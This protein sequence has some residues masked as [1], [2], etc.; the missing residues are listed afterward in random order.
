MVSILIDFNKILKVC[1]LDNNSKTLIQI[2]KRIEKSKEMTMNGYS[3]WGQLLSDTAFGVVQ[4]QSEA[5]KYY[6]SF[7]RADGS[8]GCFDNNLEPC[9]GQPLYLPKRKKRR[10]R[11]YYDEYYNEDDDSYLIDGIVHAIKDNLFNDEFN[12]G[13]DFSFEENIGFGEYIPR[14]RGNEDYNRQIVSRWD[15]GKPC[16]HVFSLL[17]GFCAQGDERIEKLLEN[18][19]TRSLKERI[20]P[21]RDKKYAKFIQDRFN[22]VKDHVLEKN[23][24]IPL[25]NK[26]NGTYSL[27][28]RSKNVKIIEPEEQESELSIL[29]LHV[30]ISGEKVESL[31]LKNIICISCLQREQDQEILNHWVKCIHCQNHLCKTCFETFTKEKTKPTCP[32][33]FSGFKEHFLDVVKFNDS[34]DKKK[35]ESSKSKNKNLEK[36]VIFK[37]GFEWLF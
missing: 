27:F 6:F 30:K 19:I 25:Q 8:Y 1:G 34:L 26:S 2:K 17:N 31:P 13:E 23:V 24:F 15:C 14:C 9:L 35:K 10:K 16:K 37:F 3:L 5:S 21:L 28:K 33:V 32:S 18:W 36:D 22:Q 4:S 20:I 7:I 29:E 12:E 11:D